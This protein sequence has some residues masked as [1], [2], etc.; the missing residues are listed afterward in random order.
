MPDR[1]YTHS[2]ETDEERV[3]EWLECDQ[4]GDYP[5]PYS[6]H[7]LKQYRW[8]CLKHVRQYNKEWNYFKDKTDEEVTDFML[9]SIVGHRPTWA[10]GVDADKRIG[11]ATVKAREVLSSL[12]PEDF[13]SEDPQ[14][15]RLPKDIRDAL[16]L[17]DMSYPVT[18]TEIKKKY[19]QLVKKYHPDVNQ[20][21]SNAEETFKKILDSYKILM[22]GSEQGI[23]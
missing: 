1:Y 22:E 17:F 13:K 6:A 2:N 7:N 5:A 23:L 18:Q 19:K 4:R 10:M 21:D 16:S 20:N 15:A 12:F 9:D 11:M 3:C 8:F 14:P